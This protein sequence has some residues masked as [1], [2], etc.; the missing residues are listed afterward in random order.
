MQNYVCN[1]ETPEE[2]NPTP[3]VVEGLTFGEADNHEVPMPGNPAFGAGP[4]EEPLE[5]QTIKWGKD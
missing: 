1:I 5:I 4:D 2:E 3:L